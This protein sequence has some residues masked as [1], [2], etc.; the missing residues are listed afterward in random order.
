MIYA[1]VPVKS[2]Q[3]G[4]SRLASTMSV[5]DRIKLNTRLLEHTVRTLVSI[6]SIGQ[7][8]VVSQD[9]N[10]L[11]IARD[12]GAKDIVEK[13]IP[14]LNSALTRAT[15]LAQKDSISGVLILPVD[16]PLFS[17]KDILP[18]IILGENPPVVVIS[19]DKYEDGTNALLISPPGLMGY[20]FG[21]G[22]FE[23]HCCQAKQAGARLEIVRTP[24]LAFDLDN[25]EDLQLLSEENSIW[26]EFIH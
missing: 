21:P 7:V 15:T 23:R 16:M 6:K 20:D 8:F 12:L 10:V 4:K 5:E 18:L 2:F 9:S 14:H 19:P 22:S 3:M 26:L 25:P 13:G 17:E 11:K 1:I 24:S